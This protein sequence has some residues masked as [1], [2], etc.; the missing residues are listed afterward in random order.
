MADI[1]IEKRKPFWPWILL[2][3]I[4]LIVAFLYFYGSTDTEMTDESDD[5]EMEEVTQLRPDLSLMSNE[6]ETI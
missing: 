6:V 2:V 4:I 1:R 3:V 5:T